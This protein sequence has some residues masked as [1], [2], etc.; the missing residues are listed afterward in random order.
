[1]LKQKLIATSIVVAIV[2][3]AA[4]AADYL[5]NVVVLA[6]PAQF[7]PIQ[8]VLIAILV[9]T[10]VTYYLISQR[11]N[12]QR[13]KEALAASATEKDRA[14]QDAQARRAEA[15]SAL[16][17][18]R[19]SEALYRLLTDN[20]T[21]VISL[22]TADGERQYSSPSAERA[23]GFTLDEMKRLPK[24][25]NAHPDDVPIIRAL[26][27]SL[28]PESG[29]KAA[30][31]RLMHKDGSEIWVEGAFQRLKDGSGGMISTTRI[32][33]ERK[34]LQEEL[35]KAL[36]DAK[37]A[38]T[39][40]SDFLS[41]MTH[42]LRT[43]LNAIVGFSG[44]L[45]E[46]NA[47]EGRNARHLELICD[48]SQTLLG[49]VN[50]VLDFSKL[51]AGAVG[52]EAH[53]FD[54]TA[55][56]RFTVDL[57]AEQ[58]AAKGLSLKSVSAGAEG[59]L[60]GDGARLRQ[61]LLNFVSNAVKF[62]ARGEIEVLVRQSGDTRQRKLY[63]AVS[64]SGI[65][66][67]ADQLHTIFG[68]FTQGDASV[69]RQYG[70]TGLG[71]AISK[72]II[73]ALGGRIGVES[74][75]GRGSTFWFEV[76]LP[77]AQAPGAVDAAIARDAAVDR[78]LRLLIVDD[79]AVNRELICAL[80]AP[81]DLDIQTAV[82]GIDA[83]QAA[84]HAPFD[85]IL[86]DVQMPNMDGLTATRRIRAAEA[87]TGRRVPIVAMTADVLPDQIAR[88]LE[89]GMDAHLGKPIEPGKLLETLAH[90][91]AAEPADEAEP[92]GQNAA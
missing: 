91:S 36:D 43:P 72:R 25:A 60:L 13:V 37:A 11:M 63:V 38:L 76:D 47:L 29:A 50:D 14:V 22:W 23:F 52:F 2:I 41:N 59:Y 5:T 49:V 4:L 75:P 39:A 83:V 65:G 82:D 61:V 92:V 12:M 21:D 64:D 6:S 26:T 55:M 67:P 89:A 69:S 62:T 35:L 1:M 20:Q 28:T 30:E 74:A 32:I 51:E 8:T 88:C 40:K 86:M 31:Y 44:L 7:T 17:R 57:L 9:S 48:A 70:G 19:E 27:E 24:A 54:P 78:A 87:A 81:F 15:E 90:W 77:V 56:A 85:L 46:A 84:A 42:E 66:V 18:L 79:N 16:E 68:R 10:P 45:K 34:R 71:L 73:D 33:T 3:V 58:A 53:P 80:L